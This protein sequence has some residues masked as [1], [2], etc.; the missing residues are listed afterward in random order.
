MGWSAAV[1]AHSL[2]N[3]LASLVPGTGALVLGSFWDWS[4]WLFMFLFIL[5]VLHREQQDLIHFLKEEVELGWIMP[6][7]HRTACSAW[8]QS[9]AR[10]GWL[11][12]GSYRRTSRFFQVCGELAHKKS[13]LKRLG[14]ESGNQQIIAGLR[15]ELKQLSPAIYSPALAK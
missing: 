3:T 2:H 4:G 11:L 5:W 10:I 15:G 9:A 7:Q 6:D 14:D 1:L 12:S 13:Q 8:S